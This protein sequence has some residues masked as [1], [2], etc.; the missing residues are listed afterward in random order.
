MATPEIHPLAAEHIP[1]YVVAADG[2]DFLFT[3][4]L[5]F[6]VAVI[7]LIGVGYFTLHSIPEKMAH[8]SNHPQ[9]QLVG[10]LALLALFTHN[11]IFWIAA[12]LVAGFQIPDLAAPL[13]SIAD[14]IRSLTPARQVPPAPEPPRD[15]ETLVEER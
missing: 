1:S 6:T 4:M 3:F 11:G 9:F 13:R 8:E 14:A 7:L 12:I 5:V 10:I 15:P 2:S